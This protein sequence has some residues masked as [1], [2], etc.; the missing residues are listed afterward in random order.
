MKRVVIELEE[1]KR[2]CVYFRT[3]IDL[4]RAGDAR[5]NGADGFS[6]N[7]CREVVDAALVWAMQR[8]AESLAESLR[9]QHDYRR[10]AEG[11]GPEPLDPGAMD[12]AIGD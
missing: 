6:G 5:L 2:P 12:C 3:E 4:G 1:G 10:H 8:L 7:S 9:W 11:R